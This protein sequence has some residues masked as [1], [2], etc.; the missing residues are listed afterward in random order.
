MW[1]RADLGDS[2]ET[3]TIS[4]WYGS[5]GESSMNGCSSVLSGINFLHYKHK[6]KY[7]FIILEKVQVEILLEFKQT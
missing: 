4:S 7:L 1:R 2:W 6:E 3:T 5:S